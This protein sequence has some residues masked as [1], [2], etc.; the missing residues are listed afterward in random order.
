MGFYEA[1]G[2]SVSDF[3][4]QVQFKSKYIDLN[5]FTAGIL[6]RTIYQDQFQPTW[7]KLPLLK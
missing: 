3:S 4:V 6:L 5:E 1:L 2:I 7:E